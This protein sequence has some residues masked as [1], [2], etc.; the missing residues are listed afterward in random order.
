M[1]STDPR[2]RNTREPRRRYRREHSRPPG[3]RDQGR[4]RPGKVFRAVIRTV[5]LFSPLSS[6]D[7]NLEGEQWG[8]YRLQSRRLS[9]A[10]AERYDKPWL[11]GGRKGEKSS[12]HHAPMVKQYCSISAALK[13][14]RRIGPPLLPLTF[15]LGRWIYRCCDTCQRVNMRPVLWA[16]R[17]WA[18]ERAAMVDGRYIR[19]SMARSPTDSGNKTKCCCLPGHRDDHPTLDLC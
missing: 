8:T 13:A 6:R 4:P 14:A 17:R 18:A 12:H 19:R 5:F 15:F 7:T 10:N 16:L 1:V 2:P 11:Q 3:R 9:L